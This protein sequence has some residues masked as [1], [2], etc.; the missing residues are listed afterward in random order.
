MLKKG[1][2]FQAFFVLS[3]VTTY[4]IYNAYGNVCLCSSIVKRLQRAFTTVYSQNSPLKQ[5]SCLCTFSVGVKGCRASMSDSWLAGRMPRLFDMLVV[6]SS[7]LPAIV[8]EM[9]SVP[10][11][12]VGKSDQWGEGNLKIF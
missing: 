4:L 1:K 9:C 3:C 5:E 2:K 12:V 11:F 6:E 7:P 10:E 8:F